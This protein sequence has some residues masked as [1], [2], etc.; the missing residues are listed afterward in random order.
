MRGDAHHRKFF[1]E[2]NENEEDAP[3]IICMRLATACARRLSHS[4]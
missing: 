1:I 4:T 2:I 3:S